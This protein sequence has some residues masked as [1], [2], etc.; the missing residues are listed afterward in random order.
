MKA[1]EITRRYT[2][3]MQWVFLV[4]CLPFWQNSAFH[5]SLG[6]TVMPSKKS[7]RFQSA[8]FSFVIKDTALRTTETSCGL[9]LPRGFKVFSAV[10]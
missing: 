4:K 8:S 5:I 2:P 9:A 7:D 10:H 6:K 3:F 1:V